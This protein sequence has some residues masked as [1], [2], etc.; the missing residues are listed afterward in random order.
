[1]K[2]FGKWLPALL[3][4]ALTV[5]VAQYATAGSI[6]VVSASG[7]NGQIYK[8][9]NMDQLKAQ[10]QNNITG[11]LVATVA[12]YHN[13]QAVTMDFSTGFIY[14]IANGGNVFRFNSIEDWLAGSPS[15]NV[16]IGSQPF[17]NGNQNRVNDASYDGA[18]G[19]FY[20][21]GASANTDTP[22]DI[23]L[24]NTLDNF[25]AAAHNFNYETTYGANRV[26][27]WNSESVSGTTV[28][29]INF[30]SKSIDATYF[31]ISGGGRLEGF[32]SIADYAASAINRID[33]GPEGAFGGTNTTGFNAIVAFAVPSPPVPEP[34]SLMLCCGTM[35]G[36]FAVRRR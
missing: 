10:T 3:A 26:V 32:E 4:L 11:V 23:L 16:S 20:A 6:Y 34:T 19:G 27:F 31:Q 21:V 2:V 17:S 12:G 8:Y 9:D 1:M 15:T 24:Y 13:D 7:T 28:G 22:G 25:R 18:T 35:F 29:N 30:P 33:L 14:R 5:G 36:L